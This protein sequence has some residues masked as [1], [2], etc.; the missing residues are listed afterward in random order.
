[1]STETEIGRAGEGHAITWLKT[2]GYS[3]KLNSQPHSPTTIEAQS[4]SKRLLV[5]V[6]TTV[7]PN[8]PNRL[9]A[10]EEKLLTSRATELGAQAWEAR[11][12]IGP[13][14][15]LVGNV[16]WRRI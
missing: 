10:E 14:L 2:E 11:V 12:Q 16:L 13:K 1:M 3:V 5:Q 15:E 6:I 8:T 9:S 4:D 7:Y